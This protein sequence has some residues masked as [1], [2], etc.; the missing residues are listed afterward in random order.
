METINVKNK[1]YS[2]YVYGQER[3]SIDQTT[4]HKKISNDSLGVV[5]EKGSN[6]DEELHLYKAEEISAPKLSNNY[7]IQNALFSLGFYNGATDGN[8]TSEKSKTAIRQFQK[9]Y[10]LAEN[11]RVDSATKKKLNSAYAMKSKITNSSAVANIDKEIDKYTMDYIQREN[12]AK[13]WTFLRVGMGLTKKQAAGVC[14]NILAES[15]FSA[16]NAQDEVTIK[17]KKV[18][19]PGVHNSKDYEYKTN[20]GVGYGLIQWTYRPRKQGLEDMAKNM[21]LSVSNLNVQFAYF[22]KE[23]TT[24]PDYK[25]TWQKICNA[26]TAK[27][28]SDIFLTDIENPR[29]KNYTTRRKYGSIIYHKMKKF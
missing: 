2:S 14:G 24:E 17:K 4:E 28:A 20:D 19:Y 10:G 22:R 25:G 11:G 16:D 18:Y 12:F 23:M 27:E 29:V 21:N 1:G 5:Y 9:V 8:L 6:D 3:V 13:T 15:V 7:Q 26:E